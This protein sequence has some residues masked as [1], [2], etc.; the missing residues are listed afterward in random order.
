MYNFPKYIKVNSGAVF[1]QFKNFKN[2]F[3]EYLTVT[4][5]ITD[6]LQ[7]LTF[8]VVTRKK[9]QMNNKVKKKD[10]P[11]KIK[12]VNIGTLFSGNK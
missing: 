5:K 6:R 4:V 3:N 7:I 1:I 2:I 8:Q 10:F 9:I 11:N 12:K